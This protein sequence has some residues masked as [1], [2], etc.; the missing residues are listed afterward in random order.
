MATLAFAGPQSA[1][2]GVN[3]AE[4][5]RTKAVVRFL[6]VRKH[7]CPNIYSSDHPKPEQHEYH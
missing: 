2:F 4:Q 6:R 7:E 5:I 1:R 3:E